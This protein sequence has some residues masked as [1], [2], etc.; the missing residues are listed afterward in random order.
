MKNA[1]EREKMKTRYRKDWKEAWKLKNRKRE[2]VTGRNLLSRFDSPATYPNEIFN[3]LVT[4]LLANATPRPGQRNK[5]ST[6]TSPATAP[7]FSTPPRFSHFPPFNLFASPWNFHIAVTQF[8][9]VFP[10]LSM[11]ALAAFDC[12]G[13]VTFVVKRS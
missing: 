2:K 12:S 1:A 13:P 8:S 5:S 3:K 4:W 9:R 7:S 10:P 11:P 6:N